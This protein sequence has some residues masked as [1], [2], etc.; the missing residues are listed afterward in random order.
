ME[1]VCVSVR[2]ALEKNFLIIELR[3]EKVNQLP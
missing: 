2:H 3:W 1:F